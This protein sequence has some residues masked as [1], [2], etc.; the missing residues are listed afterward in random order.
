MLVHSRRK[1]SVAILDQGTFRRDVDRNDR[2]GTYVSYKSVIYIDASPLSAFNVNNRILK[3]CAELQGA[4]EARSTK[5]L[6]DH[7]SVY[8]KLD[9][10]HSS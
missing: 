6:H 8:A 5:Q 3:K 7:T 9:G 10:Q 2:G 1:G 4:N